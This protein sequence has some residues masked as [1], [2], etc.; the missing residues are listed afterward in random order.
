MTEQTKP[1]TAAAA[2]VRE[3][4]DALA[5]YGAGPI[6]CVVRHADAGGQCG[7][8]GVLEVYGLVFC[9]PHGEEAKAGALEELYQDAAWSLQVLD[10]PHVPDANPA[11]L[12]AV[13]GGS[14]TSTGRSPGERRPRSCSG[15]PTPPP[16]RGASTG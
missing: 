15:A 16:T 14:P 8:D 10:H 7:R 2:V 3:G 11:L 5:R 13:R 4:A 12:R 6:P 9:G 1:V